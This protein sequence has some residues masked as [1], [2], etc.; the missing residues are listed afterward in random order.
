MSAAPRIVLCY[1]ADDPDAG[2]VFSRIVPYGVMTIHGYLRAHGFDSRLHNLTG[3]PFEEI[4]RTFA[5]LK[6]DAIGVS[7]FT[8][9][10]ASAVGLYAA[11]AESAPDA[12]RIAG[13]PQATHLDAPIL[14]RA[15]GPHV[16][17]RGEGEG[18][19]LEIAE[20]LAAGARRFEDIPGLSWLDRGELRRTPEA[21][22]TEDLD[23]FHPPERYEELNGVAPG[24][25]F[26]IVITS[27]GCPAACTFCNTP[28][29]WGR[30]MRYRSA[31][32][33]VDEIELAWKRHGID[34]FSLRDDTF[35]AKK[36]RVKQLADE[37]QRR[38]IFVLWNCQSR[39]NLVDEERLLWMRQAGCDQMQFGVEAASPAILKELNKEIR[40]DQ[41]ERA[42]ALC[43]KVGIKTSAY[44]I[45][46]VPGQ[47]DAD[48]E[49]NRRLFE[50]A[51][52]MD[53]I[54]APLAYYPGTS[55]FDDA[56][57]RGEVDEE[58]FLAG[59]Q[60]ALFVRRDPHAERQFR[61]MVGAIE[62]EAPKRGF[63]REEIEGH[64]ALTDRC[65]A[66]L[67]DLGAWHEA[68]REWSAAQ[69]AYE[70]IARRWPASPWGAKALAGLRA[71][72]GS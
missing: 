39:V 49:A 31:A 1:R 34:F 40:P 50:T 42:L 30:Q 6:P 25:Q 71:R 32:S 7:H 47:T 48:L 24:E 28:L 53:G 65:F 26:P 22:P 70:E 27:R 55:L 14:A 46:G 33:V 51:G 45:T 13:G 8:F 11:A 57:A 2:D 68:H 61:R 58:L 21:P 5:A 16:I 44:F 56:R 18:P 20:Q 10:H 69:A 52:L 3:R 17:V 54:V 9:N 15:P 67:L 19:A 35:T 12:L 41:I 43:R 64:L 62:R 63:T 37:L 29:F 66:S 4:R 59:D 60:A 36:S 72:R 38:E 23:P